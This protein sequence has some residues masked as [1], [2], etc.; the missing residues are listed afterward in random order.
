MSSVCGEKWLTL[1]LYDYVEVCS[2]IEAIRREVCH[3][4]GAPTLEVF[5]PARKYLVGP[6]TID[7]VLFEGYVFIKDTGK[8]DFEEKAKRIRGNNL[9]GPLTFG[10]RLAYLEDSIIRE[11]QEQLSSI[12]YPY[13]PEIGE[14]VAGLD[15]TFAN[16]PG[17]VKKIDHDKGVADVLFNMATREVLATN[18]SYLAIRPLEDD[19]HLC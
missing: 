5:I 4:M 19:E 18:L 13:V 3:C 12:E 16:M 11:Y 7:R 10:K 15:G 9:V 1:V 14:S 6:R 8:V 17:I 2:S